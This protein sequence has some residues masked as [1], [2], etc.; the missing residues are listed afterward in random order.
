M[1]TPVSL[2]VAGLGERGTSLLRALDDIGS[3][4]VRWLCDQS[5]AAGLRGSRRA[6]YARVTTRFDDLLED[7]TLDAVVIATPAPA[8]ADLVRRALDAGKHVLVPPP[9]SL[10]AGEADDLLHRAESGNRRLVACNQLHFHPAA[11]RL[12]ELVADG[13]LGEVLYLYGSRRALGSGDESVLWGAGAEAVAAVLWLVGDEPV[14][15]FARGGPCR[16]EGADVAF[17]GLRFAT[18]IEAELR[19][20]RV[21]PEPAQ[22]LTVVGARATATL[23][24]LDVAH[25]LTI[26]ETAEDADGAPCRGDVVAPRLPAGDPVRA[27]CEHFLAA[28][29]AP[30]VASGRGGAAVVGVLEALQ[31]SLERGGTREAIG[32]PGEPI[33]GV[34]RLP[35]RSA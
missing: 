22:R 13:H 24:V 23:D 6:P 19:L 7:E 28:V 4:E 14:E 15:A 11:A 32:A 9:L 30:G 16:G 17:C 12:R 34:I 1:R 2:A 3:A 25:P 18:G 35:I 10:D 31:Q 26:H 5:P 27:L 33:A 29:A 8:R 21:E 20:S